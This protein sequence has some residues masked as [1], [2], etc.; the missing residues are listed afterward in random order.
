MIEQKEGLEQCVFSMGDLYF[1]LPNGETP[2]KPAIKIIGEC[3][4][5]DGYKQNCLYKVV[6]D[7]YGRLKNEQ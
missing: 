7:K 2:D 6:M 4:Q 1:L 5:C 3:K